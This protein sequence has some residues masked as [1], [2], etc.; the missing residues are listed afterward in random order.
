MTPYFSAFQFA[1]AAGEGHCGGSSALSLSDPLPYPPPPHTHTHLCASQERQARDI[2]V[3]AAQNSAY[4]RVSGLATLTGAARNRA[5]LKA[6]KG[7]P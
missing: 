5:L 2:V 7:V 6:F 3:R 1:G 4:Q